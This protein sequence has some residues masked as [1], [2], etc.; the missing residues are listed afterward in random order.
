MVISNITYIYIYLIYIL[1]PRCL[2]SFFFSLSYRQQLDH[3]LINI[4]ADESLLPRTVSLT[5]VDLPP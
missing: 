3:T 4:T 1:L 2:V 5:P